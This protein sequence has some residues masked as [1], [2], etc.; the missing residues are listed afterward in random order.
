MLAGAPKCR[1]L[2]RSSSTCLCWCRWLDWT[3]M[4]ANLRLRIRSPRQVRSPNNWELT[5]RGIEVLFVLV[6]SATVNLN[7]TNAAVGTL[8]YPQSYLRSVGIWP[9]TQDHHSGSG[10]APDILVDHRGIGS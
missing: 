3:S 10:H 8:H 4:V 5:F 1:V 2:L 7:L 6:H 9:V